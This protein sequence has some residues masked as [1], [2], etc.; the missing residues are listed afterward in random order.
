MDHFAKLD[1]ELAI[2]QRNGKLHRNF[3]GYSTHADCDLVGMGITAISK[4]GDCYSQ[5]V[6]QLEEYED[7]IKIEKIP[8]YR[9]IM[10]DEDDRLRRDVILALACN[11][12]IDYE[13]IQKRYRIDFKEYFTQ[14]LDRL[15]KIAEDGLICIDNKEIS[16][17]QSGRLLIRNICM[18]FDNYLNQGK[19]NGCYS[20]TV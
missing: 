10:L 16:V 13:M 9:G 8:I 15:S 18:E 4:I 2:A 20:K 3:Q 7:K 5:N 6:R 12:R 19:N 11:F 14:E 1:D 17:T